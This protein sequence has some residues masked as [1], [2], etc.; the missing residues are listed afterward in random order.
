MEE[1]LS[2]LDERDLKMIRAEEERTK[3]FKKWQNP[4]R[5]TPLEKPT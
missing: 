1:R 4:T 2:E 3:I 5:I